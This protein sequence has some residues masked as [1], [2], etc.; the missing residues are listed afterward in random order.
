MA[1]SICRVEPSRLVLMPPGCLHSN[2]NH[3]LPKRL[4]TRLQLDVLCNDGL[5]RD[6][7]LAQPTVA[8]EREQD[9]NAL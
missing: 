4:H 6:A 1:N 5:E 2:Y 3:H 8:G 7:S 9:Y